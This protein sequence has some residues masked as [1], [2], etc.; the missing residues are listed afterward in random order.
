MK[1]DNWDKYFKD[2][3]DLLSKDD[4]EYKYIRFL[5]NIFEEKILSISLKLFEDINEEL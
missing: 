2:D 3:I 4:V 5:N 1:Y